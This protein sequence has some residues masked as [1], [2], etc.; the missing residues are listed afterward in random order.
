[1]TYNLFLEVTSPPNQTTLGPPFLY[2]YTRLQ[3]PPTTPPG[4]Y[5]APEIH[6][7]GRTSRKVPP[8]LLLRAVPQWRFAR[9]GQAMRQTATTKQPMGPT[10]M[11]EMNLRSRKRAVDQA[12]ISAVMSALSH[13]RTPEQYK[14]GPGR[15][16]SQPRCLCGKFTREYAEKRRHRC[17]FDLPKNFR[18]S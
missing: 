7:R 8:S 1:M 16:R 18:F 12:T 17:A 14:G 2:R 5:S 13:R 6:F 15:P 10:M 3:S 4:A 11:L 9:T